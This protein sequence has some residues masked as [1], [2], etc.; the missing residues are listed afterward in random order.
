MAR[1]YYY[2]IDL[3]RFVSAVLVVGF[4]L[5]Y[6]NRGAADYHPVWPVTWCGWIGVEIFFVISGLVIA[7]SA[8]N[9]TPLGF[10]KGRCMR[11]YPAAWCCATLTLLVVGVNHTNLPSY[12]RS[13]I[14]LPKGPWID[15]VYWTLSVEICFYAVVFLLL[16]Y[17]R[18][19]MK[20]DLAS[21]AFAMTAINMIGIL[22]L[23][24]KQCGIFDADGATKLV[25][26]ANLIFARHGSFFALGIWIWLST[27]RSL[28]VWD[29]LGFS[30]ALVAGA[31]EILL[32]GAEFVPFQNRLWLLQPLIVWGAALAAIAVFAR[33]PAKRNMMV[34]RQLGLMTYPLYLVHNVVGR[35]IEREIIRL[36]VDKWLALS[37]SAVAVIGLSWLICRFIEPMGRDLMRRVI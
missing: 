9:A 22:V 30:L 23:A 18:L 28:T 37:A 31:V 1:P 13:I 5:G 17:Q 34:L 29:K 4:H 11:L 14:L 24:G 7:N 2:E 36:G 35:E 10:L 15:D 32:R 6:L 26:H 20:V 12:L 8:S 33:V 3:I 21:L 25:D 19:S 16:V 27:V